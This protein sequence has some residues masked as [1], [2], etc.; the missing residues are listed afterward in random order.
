[1]CIGVFVTQLQ[2]LLK[3]IIF[4][5]QGRLC[6][7]IVSHILIVSKIEIIVNQC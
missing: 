5:K 6:L 7:V 1:M 4:E 2:S 3:S